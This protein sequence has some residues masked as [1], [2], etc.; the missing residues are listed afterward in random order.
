MENNIV[1]KAIVILAAIGLSLVSVSL[2]AAE[3]K[4]LRVIDGDTVKI[5]AEWIPAP[6]DN[7]LS[8]RIVGVDTPE[9]G[10][11]AKCDA[12]A[13]LSIAAT[14]Y[15]R[16]KIEAAQTVEIEFIKWDKFG[17]RVLGDLILDGIS[18][19]QLLLSNG[20]ARPYQGEK[21]QSWCSNEK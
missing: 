21:K 14:L 11:R 9:K 3:S 4:V 20:F 16:E 15:V 7:E 19:R 8:L 2:F 13:E 5:S 10:G 6:L 17:G 12:E 18:L 1:T